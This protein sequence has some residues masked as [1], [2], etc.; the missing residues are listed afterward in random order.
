MNPRRF[1]VGAIP[2][3]RWITAGRGGPAS[4][5]AAPVT[6]SRLASV[7]AAFASVLLV[8]VA[9]ALVGAALGSAVV[10]AVWAVL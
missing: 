7:L 2:Q 1:H 3:K 9:F 5:G 8:V 4:P 10:L 6:V